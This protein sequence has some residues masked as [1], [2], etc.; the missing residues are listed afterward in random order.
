M[1][2]TS[3]TPRVEDRLLAARNGLIMIMAA[4]GNDTDHVIVDEAAFLEAIR[5]TARDAYAAVLSV[6]RC[7]D[8]QT[9]NL[10]S[11]DVPLYET[12]EIGGVR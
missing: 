5:V 4:A 12:V 1:T 6:S 2:T 11:P 10:E 3:H 7:L 8:G 9:Q